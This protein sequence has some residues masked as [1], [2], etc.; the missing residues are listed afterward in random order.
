MGF[1]AHHPLLKDLEYYW[2]VQ[3]GSRY[4]CDIPTDPFKKMKAKG[5]KLCKL[6]HLTV[7]ALLL[8]KRCILCSICIDNG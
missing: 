6:R 5:Q 8:T 7:C 1:I 2:K 4:T 3:P